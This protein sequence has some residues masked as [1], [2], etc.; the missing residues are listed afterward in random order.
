MNGH[1]I[2]RMKSKDVDEKSVPFEQILLFGD[3]ITQ[4]S[5]RNR[6]KEQEDNPIVPQTTKA[7]E[8]PYGFCFAAALQNR[9]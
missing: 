4:G 6:L 2:K 8:N 3:S 9:W 1:I 7:G 5:A